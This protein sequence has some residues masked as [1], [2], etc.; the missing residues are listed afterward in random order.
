MAAE[1]RDAKIDRIEGE[2]ARLRSRYANLKRTTRYILPFC[3]VAG[4]L[5]LWF[6]VYSWTTGQTGAVVTAVLILLAL[7]GLAL[8]SRHERFIVWA[9]SPEGNSSFP[10]ASYAEQLESAISAR[11]QRLAELK[12]ASSR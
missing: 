9:S 10:H 2:L 1:T 6:L 12:S 11:E 4:A 5:V 8:A 3:I 7:L